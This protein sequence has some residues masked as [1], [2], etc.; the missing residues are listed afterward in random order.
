LKSTNKEVSGTVSEISKS[1]TNTGGQYL[2]KINVPASKDLLP[3]MF[4]NV[5][6]PFKNS[7][8]V[9]QDFQEGVMIP[10]SAIVENGQLTGVYTVSSQNTA[11]LRWVKVGKTFGDQVE[12]LS[13]LNANDQYIISAQGKL[14]NGAKVTLK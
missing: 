14:F 5:Q 7:G 8:S 10:K 3:G 13:G 12:I 6:F 9:N 4:V 11:V 1:S 2:V